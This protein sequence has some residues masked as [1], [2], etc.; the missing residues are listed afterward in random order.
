[1][2]RRSFIKKASIGTAGLITAFHIPAFSQNRKIKIGL[3]GCGWYGM[4]I[5]TAA[6]KVGGV[7]VIA[8]CDVDSEHLKNSAA[9]IESLQGSR[10]KTFKDYREL[11]GLKDL[12]AVM[13]AT[14]PHWHALQFVAACKKGLDIYCEK[15]LAYDVREGKAM[16][17][18]AERAGNIVQ[19]G[20]QR[21][22]SSAFQK[23]KELIQNGTT[24]KIH[25]IGAQIHYNPVLEDN[26]IQEPPASLDWDAWCGPAPKLPY[27]PNIGHKAWR[28]E[29][30]YGNGHLVDWG[31]HHIDI[32]RTIMDF[33]IPESFQ[34][35]GNLEMLKGKITT[36]DT[37]NAS[38]YFHEMPVFW[39]H[40]LWGT[41]DL[42]PQFNNGVF[43]YGEKA[44]LFASDYKLV[45]MPAGR[46][47]RQQ[48]MDIPTPDMQE[49]HVADFIKAVKAKDKRLLSC[50]VED[51]WKS[52]AT[53]QLAMASYYSNK[54]VKWDAAAKKVSNNPAAAE[55]MARKYR[56]GYERPS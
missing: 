44:T 23:A 14:P 34:A 15:P 39:Q 11:L 2:Y 38:L 3:I 26:T 30:E 52:T 32:I 35:T 12:E 25:Q 33:E 54:E 31:I 45:L 50:T 46:N 4:V 48:E 8:V 9:E 24:G 10:P 7:E 5:T 43:F 40:R 16:M 56:T 17:K 22:Q 49:K 29:K 42:N 37:L 36:P 28:L 20:F 53:V 1:M 55:L 18:A 41:G 27:R 6:L 51:A 47:Q 21:R 19:V 13:I